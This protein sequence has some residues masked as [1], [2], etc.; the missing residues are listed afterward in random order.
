MSVLLA[1][2]SLGDQIK[3]VRRTWNSARMGEKH[4]RQTHSEGRGVGGNDH[5]GGRNYYEMF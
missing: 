1:E 2:Y 4:G 3:Q 5:G